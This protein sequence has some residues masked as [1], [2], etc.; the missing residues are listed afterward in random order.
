MPELPEVETT[1]RG[2]APHTEGRT[3][4]DVIVRQPQLRWEV[5]EA[6]QSLVGQPITAVSRRSKYVLLEATNGTAMIHLGMSGSL[7]VVHE[8]ERE[9]AAQDCSGF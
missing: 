3:V 2:I 8:G 6:I 1:C 5:P 7:R 4:T 9:E